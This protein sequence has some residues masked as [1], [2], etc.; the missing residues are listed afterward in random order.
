M[1]KPGPAKWVDCLRIQRYKLRNAIKYIC[2]RALAFP[3][4]QGFFFQESHKPFS[5]KTVKDD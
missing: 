2:Q 4:M 1:R 3:K 5:K